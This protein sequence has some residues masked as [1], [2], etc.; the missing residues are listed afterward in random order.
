MLV[1][2]HIRKKRLGRPRRRWDDNIRI[3]LQE[4]GINTRIGIIREP[5]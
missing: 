1:N 5:L 2:T 3:E 4:I